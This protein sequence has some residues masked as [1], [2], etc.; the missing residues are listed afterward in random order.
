MEEVDSDCVVK[1]SIHCSLLISVM[2]SK[3]VEDLLFFFCHSGINS[4]FI[5]SNVMW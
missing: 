5:Q 3:Q 1:T 4:S 2:F